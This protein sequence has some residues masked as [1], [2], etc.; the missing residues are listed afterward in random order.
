MNRW[1][2]VICVGFIAVVTGCHPGSSDERINMGT[3]VR[4]DT[5]TNNRITRPIGNFVSYMVGEGIEVTNVV[6][7]VSPRGFLEVQVE[8]YNHAKGRRIIDYRVEWLDDD[9]MVLDTIMTHWVSKSVMP[10]SSSS[11]RVIAPSRLATDFRIN[12]RVNKNVK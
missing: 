9:G 10:G 5:L 3:G 7:R 2:V 4:S 11:F 1:S 8:I 12:T 6:E